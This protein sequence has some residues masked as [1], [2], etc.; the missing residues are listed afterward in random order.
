MGESN[1]RIRG[2]GIKHTFPFIGKFAG[3]WLLVSMAAVLVAG[4]TTFLVLGHRGEGVTSGATIILVGETLFLLVALF[5]LAVFTTHRLA[6]PWIAVHHAL[7][8]VKEGDLDRELRIRNVDEHLR[9]VEQEFN[10][11]MKALRERCGEVSDQ[12]TPRS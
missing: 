11:M 2:S 12:P 8:D 1:Y 7:R 6:G 10:A 3:T 9:P 5:A 4:V